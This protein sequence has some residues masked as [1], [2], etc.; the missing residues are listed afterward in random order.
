MVQQQIAFPAGLRPPSIFLTTAR[1][2]NW[3]GSLFL[4][5]RHKLADSENGFGISVGTSQDI[6]YFRGIAVMR[7]SRFSLF[8]QCHQGHLF[9]RHGGT[10]RPFFS[11]PS[12][13]LIVS[14]GSCRPP[15]SLKKTYQHLQGPNKENISL[16]CRFLQTRCPSPFYRLAGF[17]PIVRLLQEGTRIFEWDQYHDGPCFTKY[18]SYILY[19]WRTTGSSSVARPISASPNE[20]HQNIQC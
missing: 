7:T 16:H 10:L 11:A 17:T 8:Y 18:R 19:I 3:R 1:L 9:Y 20:Y 6:W 15:L 4:A 5:L 14:P 2:L 13:D 12:V